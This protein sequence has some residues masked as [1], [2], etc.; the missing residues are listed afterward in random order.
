MPPSEGV[1]SWVGEG[2]ERVVGGMEGGS[3]RG[4]A[5]QIPQEC[6]P[7]S[8][9]SWVTLTRSHSSRCGA[10][11][12]APPAPALKDTRGSAAQSTN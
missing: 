12:A 9:M 8:L 10:I 4:A 5:Q 3:E 2:E 11:R 6:S 7:S 1:R